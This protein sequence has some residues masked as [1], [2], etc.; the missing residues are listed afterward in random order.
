M[1]KTWIAKARGAWEAFALY[2]WCFI[3]TSIAFGWLLG[4]MEENLGR[5]LIAAAF[6]WLILTEL[7]GRAPEVKGPEK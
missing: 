2:F 4:D 1:K 5:Y 3:G 7:V 6:V